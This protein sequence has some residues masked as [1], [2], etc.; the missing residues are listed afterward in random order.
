MKPDWMRLSIFL[1]A[2][3]CSCAFCYAQSASPKPTP[4]PQPSEELPVIDGGVGPCSVEFTVTDATGKPVYAANV[5]VHIAYGFAGIRKLDLE[6]GTNVH[7]KVKFKGLP[8]KVH[9]P[10]LEFNASKDQLV[11]IAT[12]DPATECQALHDIMLDKR[13]AAAVTRVVPHVPW[14]HRAKARVK[15]NSCS[16]PSMAALPPRPARE[17]LSAWQQQTSRASW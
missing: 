7:G 4:T 2:V 3:I 6:A 9:N 5:K 15:K 17:P 11:G 8:I 14:E 1:G 13:K 16:R 12:Y 10:P